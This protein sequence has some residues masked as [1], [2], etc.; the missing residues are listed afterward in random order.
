M[1]SGSVPTTWVVRMSACLGVMWWGLGLGKLASCFAVILIIVSVYLIL[2]NT[3]V[4]SKSTVEPLLY[5]HPQ[6]H[7]G[8][9]V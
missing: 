2:G 1:V 5:D 8:V 6:N 4:N 9:V 3:P 7:I